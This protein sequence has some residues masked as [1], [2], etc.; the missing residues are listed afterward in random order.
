MGASLLLL[1]LFFAIFIQM[2]PLKQGYPDY[3]DPALAEAMAYLSKSG[4]QKLST[5]ERV[6][7]VAFYLP[8][9][10]REPATDVEKLLLFGNASAEEG[11]YLLLSLPAL[12]TL[13]QKGGFEVYY[14]AQNYTN[15]GVNYALFISQ[16]GRL[17]SRE[18]SIG[19]KFALKDGA[20]LDSYGRYYAPVSLPRMVMLDETKPISDNANRM[21][22][23]AEG[24]APP[25]LAGIYSG[26]DSGVALAKE[27]SG[28]SVYKVK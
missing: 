6:D 9:I 17:I 28:V 3:T 16:Q 13:S 1:S 24:G 2:P 25:R 27:F 4:A 12:E 23:L 5:L 18:L 26:K 20:A 10:T 21:L 11:T 19:G 15:N 7:A 8:G 14:Y 22:V